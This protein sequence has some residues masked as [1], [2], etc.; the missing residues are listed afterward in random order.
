MINVPT[1][2]DISCISRLDSLFFL[3]KVQIPLKPIDRVDMIQKS[4]WLIDTIGCHQESDW[5][6]SLTLHLSVKSLWRYPL[7]Y[8]L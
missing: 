7:T 8:Y 1:N 3:S 6:D 2:P 4:V 5:S